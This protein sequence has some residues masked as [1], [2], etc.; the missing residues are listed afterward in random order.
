VKPT[1]PADATKTDASFDED[2]RFG[3]T[4]VACVLAYGPA[5]GAAVL[6][7]LLV[8]FDGEGLVRFVQRSAPFAP[9]SEGLAFG[10]GAGAALLLGIVGAAGWRALRGPVR[11][12]T[13]GHVVGLSLCPVASVWFWLLVAGAVVTG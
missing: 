11:E 13:L 4:D 6:L 5:L 9:D 2:R 7:V 3:L 1:A 10:M 8:L 12:L